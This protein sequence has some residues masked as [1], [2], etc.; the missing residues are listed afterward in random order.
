MG[1]ESAR[2]LP[3]P[4]NGVQFR[5]VGRQKVQSEM[6]AMFPQPRLQKFG[7]MP[8]GIIQ[9]DNHLAALT[10][11]A[12]K[13]LQ[14]RKECLRIEL[15]GATGGQTSVCRTNCA[16]HSNVFPCRCMQNHRI[17]ILWRYPHGTA[18]TVLLEMAFIFEPQLNVVSSGQAAE[19]FYN[20]VA[21]AD[22]LSQ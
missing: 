16:K 9:N 18:R 3:H 8:A 12:H 2:Q 20:F 14:E 17:Y 15:L 13:L 21:P 5:A 10:A 6:V 22:R 4:F 7:T 11:T 19:F 1:A